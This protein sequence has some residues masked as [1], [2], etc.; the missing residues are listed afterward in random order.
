M[1]CSGSSSI[2]NKRYWFGNLSGKPVVTFCPINYCNF[3]CCE[4]TN[5]Y[6]HLYPVRDNQCMLH[7]SGIAC[8]SCEVGYS[9]SFDSTECTDVK[10]CTIGQTILLVILIIL[11]WIAI[12]VT[13][14]VMMYFKVEIGYLY[15]TTY[16]YS[17]A[18]VLLT[19]NWF[20]FNKY[21][22][23]LINIMSSMTKITP[24]LLGHLCLVQGMSGI[25]QQFLHYI[26]PLAVSFTIGV[27]TCLA[28]RS[29]RLS[30]FISRGII[31]FICFLL[32]LSYTSVATTSLLLMRPLTFHNMDKIYTY[33]SPDIEYFHG[34]HPLYGIIAVLV[35][36]I[37][38]FGLPFIL[39]FEPVL[40]CKINFVKIKP[41]L[42]QFQGCYKDKYR[43]FAAYYMICR[44]VIIVI[45]IVN[46]PNDFTTRYLIITACVI[47]DLMHHILKPYRD[48]KLNLFDGVVLHLAILVSFLPLVEFFDSFN[49][50]LV[51]GAA[52][53]LVLLP[54][55]GLITMKLLIHRRNIAKMI[56][57]CIN[58]IT[59]PHSRNNN[60]IPLKDCQEQLLREDG[61]IVDNNIKR[62]AITA[63]V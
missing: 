42:D 54:L 63:D 4:T 36:I 6:Y 40:S 28:R 53:V 50:D 15:G 55:V 38:T 48:N 31:P 17:I 7:R 51:I 27:I 60:D 23:T 56:Y 3:T 33:L 45:I 34:R 26:H 59:C 61:V 47:M 41:L 49:S 11:Y 46:S 19:Q 39:L 43:C 30:S 37:I 29:R 58:F 52:Y 13:V 2:I 22:H 44:L 35:T 25:D 20:L 16:Y 9:L 5:G 10:T 1:I 12:I 24:Q 62:N 18:D 14:F 21:L 8:G 32:L 57:Y